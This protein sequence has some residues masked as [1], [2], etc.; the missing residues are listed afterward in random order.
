[1]VNLIGITELYVHMRN[2]IPELECLMNQH[3]QTSI[4]IIVYQ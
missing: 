1:M 4:H 3:K 2:S